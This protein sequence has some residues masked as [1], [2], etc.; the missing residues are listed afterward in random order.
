MAVD[1]IYKTLEGIG[2]TIVDEMKAII[3]TGYMG[4]PAIASGKLINSID[5]DIQVQ[6][7]VWT[8]VIEYADYGKWV[9][10]GRNPGR[11]PPKAAIE[12]W[13]RMKGLPQKAVWPIMVKIKKGGFYSKKIA[14][15]RGT[16]KTTGKTG[17][18]TIYS[19]PVKGLHFTSPLDKNLELS[20]LH[21]E[22]GVAFHDYIQ[23][24]FD[25]IKKEIDTK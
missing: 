25:K 15:V 19:T 23:E 3:Q 22:L 7:G 6:D 17:Q 18:S 12:N 13:V 2:K 1:N 4:R 8:L 14:M 5:Y 20:S 9:N 10:N 16:D 24:E 11:F 21:K